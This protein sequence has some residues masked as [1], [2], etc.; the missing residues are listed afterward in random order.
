MLKI[1][2]KGAK[3]HKFFA[4]PISLSDDCYLEFD[5]INIS[6]DWRPEDWGEIKYRYCKYN[7]GGCSVK[8]CKSCS[9]L[10]EYEVGAS[11]MLKALEEESAK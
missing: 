7:F 10:P 6:P 5:T 1:V 11:A 9:L 3:R 2:K 8:D 4:G